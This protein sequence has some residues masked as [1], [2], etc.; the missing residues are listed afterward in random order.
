[1]SVQS[2]FGKVKNSNPEVFIFASADDGI[3]KKVDYFSETELRAWLEE[4]ILDKSKIDSMIE[5]AR[6][7]E[8][9]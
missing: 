1:M 8:V 6:H 9:L 4:N 5:E 7:K 3:M 2:G